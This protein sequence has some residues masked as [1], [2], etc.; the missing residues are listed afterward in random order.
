M[1]GK[2][3]EGRVAP[4]DRPIGFKVDCA[5]AVAQDPKTF[6]EDMPEDSQLLEGVST[7]VFPPSS[8]SGD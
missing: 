6:W 1:I 8:D 2:G 4:P 3:E 5:T 7:P